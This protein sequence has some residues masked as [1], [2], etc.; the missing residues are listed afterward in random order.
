MEYAQVCKSYLPMAISYLPRFADPGNDALEVASFEEVGWHGVVE[1]MPGFV[2]DLQAFFA[3]GRDG[4]Q[5]GAELFGADL[6]GT[7]SRHQQAIGGQTFEGQH[8]E[9][10]IGLHG[11]I[12]LLAGAGK[13]G[14]IEN[15]TVIFSPIA[16]HFL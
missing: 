7:A 16:G 2:Q 10:G 11:R 4:G 1:G 15:D 8:I 5:H 14:R 9:A 13:A 6:A 12:T 3:V